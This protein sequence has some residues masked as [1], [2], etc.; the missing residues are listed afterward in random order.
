MF[1]IALMLEDCV[2]GSFCPPVARQNL[3]RTERGPVRRRKGLMVLDPEGSES[4][5]VFRT[6]KPPARRAYPGDPDLRVRT[7]RLGNSVD[8][9]L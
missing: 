9:S 6:E 4:A 7:L 5:E 1:A 3:I 8:A 2:A